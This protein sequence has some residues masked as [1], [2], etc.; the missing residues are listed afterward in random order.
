MS[1]KFLIIIITS[2]LL[3]AV[4]V[5]GYLFLKSSG[6]PFSET[7][8]GLLPFGSGDD[9]PSSTT[10]TENP[11]ETTEEPVS[12]E[13]DSS[14]KTFFQLSD[15]PVA[16]AVVLNK[17][18]STTVAR[19]VDRAT[20]HIYEIDL[21][22][23][24]KTKITNQ[25]LPKIY[26][27]YFR[28][29]GKAVLVRFLK[30]DTDLVENLSFALS[31]PKPTATSSPETD[32]LYTVVSTP[33]RGDI[34][35]VTVGSGDNLIY[36]L[37]DSLSIVSSAFNGS[38]LKTLFSSPFT[39][40]RLMTSGNSL[41]VHTKASFSVPGYAYSLNTSSGAFTKILGPFNALTALSN[42]QGSR[43]LYSYA[44]NNETLSF[45]KNIPADDIN[46]LSATT[47][48]DKC[49]WS[50]KNTALVFCGVPSNKIGINEP[51]NWYKGVSV[52][53]DRV[54][55][56]DTDTGVAQVLLEL[57]TEL[58]SIDVI[59][60]KLSPNEDY[61]IFINKIDLTLWALR[62]EEL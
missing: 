7:V 50:T 23:L 56:F 31:L 19:Y 62:L 2:I 39:N 36:S 33:I 37:E 4:L 28:T 54:W 6:T 16:G 11:S 1:K 15:V 40:W 57:P 8:S 60:P 55:S 30:D 46:E 42:T 22:T 12:N 21:L 45:V 14:E 18:S 32:M 13:E 47:L 44:V 49:V 25:T 9:L 24:K 52:F 34:G 17:N 48:A 5:G 43:V 61:L 29:D 41:V 51:D 58:G 10:E 35:S 27:A 38:G 26:E 59:E 20:G 53:Y 3:L